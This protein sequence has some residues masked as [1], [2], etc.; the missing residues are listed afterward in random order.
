MELHGYMY[1]DRGSPPI[2]R[3]DHFLYLRTLGLSEVP[4]LVRGGA[5]VSTPDRLPCPPGA[6]FVLGHLCPM[7]PGL[8]N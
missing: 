3:E 5:G 1:Y 4:Q 2:F 8:C 6:I 7:V